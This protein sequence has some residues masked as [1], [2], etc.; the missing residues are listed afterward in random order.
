MKV[1]VTPLDWGLGHATRC[2][3]MVKSMLQ[4]GWNITL[5]GEGP[6]LNILTKEFP[7]LPTLK[8]KGYRIKYPKNGFW[9][10]LN[11]LLQVPKIIQTIRA[12]RKWLEEAQKEHQWDLII[13][14]NRY[15]LS[16]PNAKCIF[17]THQLWVLSGWGNPIDKILNKQLH[18][19]I[20]SFDQCWIPDE[21]KDG[22]IAGIL[23]HPP[24]PTPYSL[25]P[26]PLNHIGPLSRLIPT[27]GKESDK[28]LILLSGPEPQRSLLEEKI[29]HQIKEID[30]QFLVVRGLPTGTQQPLN[31]AHIEFKNHLSSNDLSAAISSAKLV[32]CRS[33]YSSI[34]DLLRMKK[35]AILIPTPGQT[36][37]LYL[38]KRMQEKNWFVVHQQDDFQLNA[39]I[40]FCLQKTLVAPT[41]NFELH[42]Q[43]LLELVTQ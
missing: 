33:G 40:P 31:S 25:L 34:M 26:I 36:E 20:K 23:S 28:I 35:K 32:I 1:L 29:I 16:V 9:L 39:A 42:K 18:N 3:P 15:G 13:S 5:A 6:S 2:V 41:L 10:I 14:D 7:E 17:M 12:E 21:E 27:A 4:L 11:L 38:A 43:V 8:L 37:Q 19:W 22:G 24:F 30:E